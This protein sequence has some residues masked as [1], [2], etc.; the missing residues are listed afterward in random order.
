MSTCWA[1]VARSIDCVGKGLG[2]AIVDIVLDDIAMDS[3]AMKRNNMVIDQI[4]PDNLWSI[5]LFSKTGFT[6]AGQDQN[7]S[8]FIFGRRS[9]RHT[10]ISRSCT[11]L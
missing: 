8:G 10:P 9:S 6:D 7:D 1:W 3:Y 5:A 2:K 4:C 11:N